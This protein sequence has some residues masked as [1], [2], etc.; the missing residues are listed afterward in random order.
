MELSR[1]MAALATDRITLEDRLA[2]AI[3]ALLDRIDMIGMAEQTQRLDRPV[4]LVDRRSQMRRQ[5]PDLPFRVPTDGRLKKIAV[6]ICQVGPPAY[7]G[8]DSE[9]NFHFT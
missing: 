4:E 8:A 5:I 1:S 9:L 2:I 7:P 3:A 6:A